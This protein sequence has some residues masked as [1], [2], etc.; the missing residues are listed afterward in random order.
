MLDREKEGFRGRPA[1]LNI[2]QTLFSG[3]SGSFIQEL[4]RDIDGDNLSSWPDAFGGRNG[5]R[6]HAATNIEN[7]HAGE[8]S[9]TIDSSPAE[10]VPKRNRR[11]IVVVGRS[12]IGFLQLRLWSGRDGHNNAGVPNED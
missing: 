7:G 11:L 2:C 8:K 4:L 5:G 6:T 9:K 3:S 1:K 12:V 10:T